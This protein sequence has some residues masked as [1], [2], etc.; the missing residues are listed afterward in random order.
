M[1]SFADVVVTCVDVFDASMEQGVLHEY[2]CTTVIA[3]ER[4]GCELGKNDRHEKGVDPSEFLASLACS[5]ILGLTRGK[6]DYM[7]LVGGPSD[8]TKAQ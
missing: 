4:G 8:H 1:N 3:H 6:S 5:N 7:L 2:Q